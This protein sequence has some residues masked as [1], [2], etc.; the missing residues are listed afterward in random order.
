METFRTAFPTTPSIFLYRHPVEALLSQGKKPAFQLDSSPMVKVF[1]GKNKMDDKTVRKQMHGIQLAT[2]CWSALR[3]FKD[4]D[5]LGLAVKYSYDLASDFIDTIF[6]KHF[7]T[8]V[9]RDGEER[10]RLISK[11]YNRK[12][13]GLSP[14]PPGD[15]HN[16]VDAPQSIDDA[17][18]DYLEPSFKRLQDSKYNLENCRSFKPSGGVYLRV[19][20]NDK[21]SSDD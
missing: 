9:E 7:H 1:T 4:A 5:G 11:R 8:P 21:Q 12:R 2:F 18:K 3:N 19:Q 10:I 13:D 6:P 20:D 17:A 15:K 14:G 16:D